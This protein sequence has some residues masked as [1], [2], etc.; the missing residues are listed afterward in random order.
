MQA[1][2]MQSQFLLFLKTLS[3]T[4]TS[5][6]PSHRSEGF[7]K[8]FIHTSKKLKNVVCLAK[9]EEEVLEKFIDEVRAFDPDIITGW[10]LID[11]DLKFLQERLRSL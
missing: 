4:S 7:E 9:S 1:R 5:L 3:L 11:F 6:P 8:T 2:F 10:N